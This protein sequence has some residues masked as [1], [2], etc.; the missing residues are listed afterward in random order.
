MKDRLYAMLDQQG[1]MDIP[2][3]KPKGYRSFKR[4]KSRGGDK[5]A[6]FP[7]HFVAEPKAQKAP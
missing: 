5:A 6:D 3:N 1:G 2:M 7:A 4:L